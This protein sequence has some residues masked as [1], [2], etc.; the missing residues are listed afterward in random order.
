MIQKPVYV[1][2]IEL[3]EAHFG[4]QFQKAQLAFYYEQFSEEL[5]SEQFVTACKAVMRN[6]KF[7]PPLQTF[8][9]YG[10]AANGHS[11]SDL[12]AYQQFI[13]P[14]PEDP[15]VLQVNQ[16]K[17]AAMVKGIG[18][19]MPDVADGQETDGIDPGLRERCDLLSSAIVAADRVILRSEA[20]RKATEFV[21]A[22]PGEAELI[23]AHDGSVHGVRPRLA[24]VVRY[25]S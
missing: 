1:Q 7:F 19:V 22:H 18:R 15:R 20:I 24:K 17:L 21:E 10:K 25:A 12:P 11:L 3:V 14:A 8:I 13:A 23:I 6:E 16:L 4:K 2:W 9:D 5:D